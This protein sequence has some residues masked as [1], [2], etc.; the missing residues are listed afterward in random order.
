[1]FCYFQDIVIDNNK[2][3]MNAKEE[4]K[5]KNTSDRK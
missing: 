4:K 1:M 5:N 3:G 2:S